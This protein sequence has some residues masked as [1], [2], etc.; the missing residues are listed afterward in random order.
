M[1]IVKT[2]FVRR[3]LAALPLK[4]GVGR[5]DDFLDFSLVTFFVAMTK[6]VT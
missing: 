2:R 3:T 5:F 4:G 6:K 1:K